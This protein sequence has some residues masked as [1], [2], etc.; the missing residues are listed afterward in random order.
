MTVDQKIQYVSGTLFA[1]L[2]N[3]LRTV[4]EA[5][6]ERHGIRGSGPN[7]AACLLSLLACEVVGNLS[8]PRGASKAERI[9]GFL[10]AVGQSADDDRYAEVAGP[11]FGFFRHGIAH[12]FLP[13][14]TR[15]LIGSA[16]W[17]YECPE[18]LDSHDGA[19]RCA[20]LRRRDH[21][22]VREYAGTT[23]FQVVPQILYIDVRRAMRQ[24][25]ASLAT[26][27]FD[28]ALFSENFDCWEAENQSLT[29]RYITPDERLALTVNRGGAPVERNSES[30][31]ADAEAE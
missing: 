7:F 15:G 9:R 27:S 10:R 28:L 8:S 6:C 29:D 25:A 24:F 20:D 11:L 3:D 5:R 31:R 16:V 14:A 2:E 22:V 26:A 30:E 17:V 1:M 18:W 13:L 19:A 23:A 21:L 12:T 4:L